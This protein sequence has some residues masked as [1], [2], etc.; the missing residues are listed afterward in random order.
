MSIKEQSER[1]RSLTD[2][3]YHG[4]LDW[5]GY[6]RQRGELLDALILQDSPVDDDGPI[7]EID[8]APV[9]Q[10][11]T[12][13]EDTTR[14]DH[15]LESEDTESEQTDEAR[16][17][18]Q[19]APA[20]PA[21]TSKESGLDR[22]YLPY[23]GG[24][25]AL[26]LAV[27]VW[28]FWPSG[29]PSDEPSELRQAPAD[30]VVSESPESAILREFADAGRWDD[31]AVSNFMLRWDGLSVRQREGLRG[32]EQFRVFVARV[33]ERILVEQAI[34][35]EP[36]QDGLTVAEALS[37]ELDLGLVDA[38]TVVAARLAA[39]AVE[40]RDAVTAVEP[41]VEPESDQIDASPAAAMVAPADASIVDDTVPK[42][43]P[44]PEPPPLEQTDLADV[45]A[46]LALV[47]R[48]DV[49]TAVEDASASAVVEQELP[50]VQESSV[51]Q[52]PPVV[53]APPVIEQESSIAAV[54]VHRS[55]QPCSAD[56]LNY[57]SARCWDM[58][59]AEV[60]APIMRVLPAGAFVMGEEGDP[61]ATPVQQQ[62]IAQPLSIG[63]FE[64]TVADYKLFC[65]DNGR[66]CP[67]PRESSNRFP[68]VDIT[69]ADASAY[70]Q[71]LSRQ[72]GAHYRLPTEVEWEYAARAGSTTRYPFGDQIRPTDA[73]YDTRRGLGPLPID[74]KTMP[75]NGFDLMHTVGNVREW[76]SDAWRTDYSAQPN[77]GE[78][79]VRGGSFADPPDRLR[80]AA[81]EGVAE[82]HSGPRTGFRV[83]REL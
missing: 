15:G 65:V 73:R 9:D 76:T 45:A 34:G 20:T 80:S 27:L 41:G 66:S 52:E 72:T 67:E 32:T 10:D 75:R 6:R 25:A 44:D 61:H 1:L 23:V 4:L 50:V 26:V 36:F 16:P 71:W 51:E 74:D 64:V 79:A 21:E 7:V 83:V 13:G 33:R 28:S 56:R 31:A 47:E 11:E 63:V 59:T 69:W 42:P 37:V 38:E 19:V 62:T 29:E 35:A 60:R 30:S 24:G 22:K 70:A 2:D 55:D 43:E 17:D 18:P 39:T 3:F 49:E 53:R 82:S 57:R 68:M 46:A 40:E 81:R 48:G 54:P 77:Q 12:S 78:R 5:D 58:I 8:A 14:R